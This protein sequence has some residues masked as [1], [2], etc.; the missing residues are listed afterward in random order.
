MGTI[1]EQ[2]VACF[3]AI[4]YD[5]NYSHLAWYIVKPELR[6]RGYGIQL[7]DKALGSLTSKTIGLYA[8][9]GK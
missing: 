3:G 2:P 9:K 8:V 1:D 5:Q 4:Q 6:F 7:W